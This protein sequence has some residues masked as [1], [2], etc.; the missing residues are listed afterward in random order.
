LIVIATAL[1]ILSLGWRSRPQNLS[2][3]HKLNIARDFL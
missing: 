1:A 2:I 3:T